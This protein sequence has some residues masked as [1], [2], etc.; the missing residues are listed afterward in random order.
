VVQE[1]SVVGKLQILEGQALNGFLRLALEATRV[2]VVVLLERLVVGPERL[3]HLQA[4]GREPYA[5]LLQIFSAKDNPNLV[6]SKIESIG[7]LGLDEA[8][9]ASA[10]IKPHHQRHMQQVAQEE[11]LWLRIKVLW[12][13]RAGV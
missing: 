13:D 11:R 12:Y 5:C 2:P 10:W 1:G 6:V 4:L 8:Q 7:N 3:E 9:Y